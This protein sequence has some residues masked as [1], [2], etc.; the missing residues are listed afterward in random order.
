LSDS[1]VGRYATLRNVKQQ[2]AIELV[3]LDPAPTEYI[4]QHATTYDYGLVDIAYLVSD[5]RKTASIFK[6]QG[7]QFIKEYH[8][9]PTWPNGEEAAVSI[10][11][12]P[13]MEILYFIQSLH[14]PV[15]GENRLDGDFWTMFDMAQTV[16]SVEEAYSFYRDALGIPLVSDVEVPAGFLD[17]VLHFPPGT[18][19]RVILLNYPQ[20]SGPL[21][22]IVKTSAPGTQL[23]STPDKLGIFMLAF[24]SDNI[25]EDLAAVNDRGFSILSGPIDIENSTYGKAAV[26][27]ING[28]SGIRIELFQKR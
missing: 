26:A 8:R 20:Y 11:Y 19:A 10:I 25:A 28:P 22:E 23:V 4:R 15:S 3:E 9:Y 21:L 1:T 6:Q 17:D 5:I 7:R 18:E 14:P 13:S 2:T 16:S 12:G 27:D 24:E